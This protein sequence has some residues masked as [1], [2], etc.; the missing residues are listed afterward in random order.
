[1]ETN[2]RY[3][4]FID[5]VLVEDFPATVEGYND[6]VCKMNNEYKD[7]ENMELYVIRVFD[8]SMIDENRRLIEEEVFGKETS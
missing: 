5:W 1:M 6:A 7:D 3:G 8:K 2:Y 4:L